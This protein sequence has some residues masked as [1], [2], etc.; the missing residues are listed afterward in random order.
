MTVPEK[1]RIP[2]RGILNAD[3]GL[4]KFALSRLLPAPELAP[5]VEHYWQVRWD[6]RG[7]P[8][9]SQTIL[10][11]P[12]VHLTFEN[13]NGRL[14]S[15]VYGVPRTTYTRRLA[16]EG[17][18]LGVKFRPGGFYPFLGEPLSR[19]TGK[20]LPIEAVFGEA[21]AALARD[22]FAAGEA[23]EMVR[24]AERFLLDRLPPPDPR[25]DRVRAV[26]EAAARERDIVKVAQLTERFG[27]APR[28]LQRLFDRYVGVHPKWIIRRF[29]LQ[30]AAEIIE[31]GEPL[32][33]SALAAQLGYFDQS[34]FIRDFKAA[35]GATPKAHAQRAA[36]KRADAPSGAA[37][38]PGAPDA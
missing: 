28:A 31:R 10:S 23:G 21:G 30:E 16:G 22:A 37:G 15:G 17:F 38:A 9:Y 18:T 3:E 29:R 2:T 13:D 33:L 24:L 19:L 36:A 6:L 34:H 32:D 11:F 8:P 5:Y 1:S 4:R 25:F 14:F 26:V 7:L 27:I 20:T 12:S 35:V